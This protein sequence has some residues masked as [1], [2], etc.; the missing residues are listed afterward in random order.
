MK[1]YLLAIKFL[2]FSFIL[3]FYSPLFGAVNSSVILSVKER[4]G[5]DRINEYVS[6][7]VPV[8]LDWDI[9]NTSTLR[10]SNSQGV[11][12]PAQFSILARWK[13]HAE[14][15]STPAKWVLIGF[16]A[17]VSANATEIFTLDRNGPGTSFSPAISADNTLPD[18]L[19]ID[20]GAAIF[21]VNKTGNENLINQVT[22]QGKKLLIP[23]NS[24][25]AIDYDPMGAVSIVTGGT[26]NTTPRTRSVV[27]ER[28]GTLNCVVKITGSIIGDT[29]NPVLD[30]TARL[31]FY[32]GS[33]DVRLDFIVEN[34]HPVIESDGAPTN[35]HAQG[36]VNSVY[37]GGLKLAMQL[38]DSGSSLRVR[39]EKNVDL[40]QP[41]SFVKLYQDSSGTDYWDVYVG[42]VGWGTSESPLA[43]ATPRLQSYC[44]Q[45]GFS[46]TGPGTS[47]TGD[48]AVGWMSASITSGPGISIGYRDFWQ[49]FPKAIQA[50]TDGTIFVD[51]FPNGSRFRHNLRVGEE[52]THTML[53]R[54]KSTPITSDEAENLA[55][56]FNTPL[57]GVAPAS[58]YVDS[59]ALGGVP[60]ANS[61]K[62]PLYENYVNVAFK[63]N[64]QFDPQTDDAGFGNTTLK[65]TIE[66]YNFFGW[67]DYG[68]VP[69]DYEAFGPNQ[70]GQM[71]LKYWYVYGM[72]LQFCRSAEL[73]WLDLALPAARHEADIDFLHIP[74][75]GIQHWVHGSYFGHSDHDEPGNTNPNRNYNSPSVD[76]FYGVPD[77]LLSYY[78]TGEQRF[79]DTALEGLEAMANLSQFSNFSYPVFY[80]ERAC[81]IFGYLEGYKQTGNSQWLTNMKTIISQTMN[82]SNKDWMTD[83]LNYTPPQGAMAFA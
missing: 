82:L 78:L 74:D 77:L 65:E 19:V 83:P 11:P 28:Q 39:T 21:E 1:V 6:F 38:A 50:E 3:L 60:E 27:V 81:L 26:P 7:G 13:G 42:D 73:N 72:F 53:F 80:R 25:S 32:A 22:I 44:S 46:V 63:P 2:I 48:Q 58:W 4:T 30:Y 52:K 36:A 5:V 23:L 70:A 59:N 18:K 45:K 79:K 57:F 75:S 68:D 54:F 41:S 43:P 64:P 69:L 10:I 8:P 14:D 34:N 33:S 51:L 71:N 76:L 55:L 29:F 35:V 31:L 17:D 24:A 49:N 15:T 37:V 12:I 61:T 47:A 56:A 16:F 66:K 40:T 62:W 67:Q 20:T 9:K